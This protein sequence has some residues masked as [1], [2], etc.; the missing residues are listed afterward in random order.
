M[1]VFPGLNLF[2]FVFGRHVYIQAVQDLSTDWNTSYR[3]SWPLV[4]IC[5]FTYINAVAVP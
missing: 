1:I 4:G 2:C 5:S 3:D